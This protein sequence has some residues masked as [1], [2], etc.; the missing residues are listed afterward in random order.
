MLKTSLSHFLQSRFNIR[1]CHYLGWPAASL[2]I[3]FLGKL[4][5]FIHRSEKRKIKAALGKVLPLMKPPCDCGYVSRR[6][7]RGLFS[8]YYEKLFN[9]YSTASTSRLFFGSHV[10]DRGLSVVRDGLA[11]GRGVLLIT[12]HYGGVEFLPGYLSVHNIP[13]SIIVRFATDHLREISVRKADAFSI[14]T[15]DPDLTPNI[16]K[17]ISEDLLANR[18]VI[19]QCDE[20]DEW[21][22]SLRDNITFLG[23]PTFLD[24]TIN[25]LSKRTR[26]HTVFGLMH[27]EENHHY[28]FVA[29]DGNETAA[30]SAMESPVS[31]GESALRF[32]EQ[33]ILR[34]PHEWYQW[35]KHSTLS[36][37]G[38]TDPA[39][40]DALP[41][42]LLH[43]SP[44]A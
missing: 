43:P 20:I 36:A 40:L 7:F 31:V 15:I 8:H 27:R 32:L 19:T 25:V 17:A 34:Y 24:K 33:Y 39:C 13:V 38:S 1:L 42:P 6:V 21:R 26:A 41:V 23:A 44:S 14:K 16:M 30:G 9:V 12:G 10:K 5:F 11:K 18:V 3:Q 37:I 22:P 35:K 28:R 4:Y 29:V 2:Y